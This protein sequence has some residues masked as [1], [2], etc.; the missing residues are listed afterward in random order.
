MMDIG[1][2]Q[3]LIK[4]FKS[5]PNLKLGI[6]IEKIKTD[7]NESILE[8]SEKETSPLMPSPNEPKGSSCLTSKYKNI[9]NFVLEDFNS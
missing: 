5:N 6:E 2:D 7:L 4:Q 8:S 3:S 9:K 1:E